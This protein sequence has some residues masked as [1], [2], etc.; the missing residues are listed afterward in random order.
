[1]FESYEKYLVFLQEKISNFFE[2]QK[3]YIVCKNG[4]AKCCKNAQFPYSELE[5]KYL[6]SGFLTLDNK[7]KEIIENN[8][9]KIKKAQKTSTQ[10]KFL[11]DC[12]FLINNSCS[13][14]DYRGVTC[15]TFGLITSA[16]NENEKIKMPFCCFEGLNYSQVYDKKTKQLS[17][18]L[19]KKNGFKTYPAGFNIK[20]SF[21]IGERFEK[22]FDVKFGKTKALI[23]W[24][25]EK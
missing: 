6:L 5:F 4:C 21:L 10:E 8:I 19:V 11:Y 13:L 15:R 3:E 9:E 20:R 25:E 16:E 24:F 1:M 23:D 14:Y 18:E 2:K 22:A 12:P 17:E 7:T